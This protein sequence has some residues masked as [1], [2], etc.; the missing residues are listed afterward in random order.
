VR[1]LGALNPK[2]NV[3]VKSLPS[4]LRGL[5]GKGGRNFARAKIGGDG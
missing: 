4:R 1:D 3:F 2:W 5:L